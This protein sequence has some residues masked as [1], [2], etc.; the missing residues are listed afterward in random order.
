MLPNPRFSPPSSDASDRATS[1]AL[2]SSSRTTVSFPTDI[3]DISSLDG[4][5]F[6][7]IDGPYQVEDDINEGTD[8]IDESGLAEQDTL[9]ASGFQDSTFLIPLHSADEDEDYRGDVPWSS[10]TG[11]LQ[12]STSL[13]TLHYMDMKPD[14]LDSQASSQLQFPD[15]LDDSFQREL[16][17]SVLTSKGEE[18]EAAPSS[19][20]S[21]DMSLPRSEGSAYLPSPQTPVEGII[22]VNGGEGTIA[23]KSIST[24]SPVGIPFDWNK[25]MIFMNVFR[26]IVGLI[27]VVI[28]TGVLPVWPGSPVVSKL[29]LPGCNATSS[30]WIGSLLAVNSSACHDTAPTNRTFEGPSKKPESDVGSVLSS[31]ALPVIK[32]TIKR[33]ATVRY[34]DEAALIGQKCSALS[35]HLA[36]RRLGYRSATSASA[37]QRVREPEG[38]FKLLRTSLVERSKLAQQ[39]ANALLVG[40]RKDWS[41]W[42]AEMDE[43]YRSVIFPVYTSTARYA[44]MQ[45]KATKSSWDEAW[46]H[47][48][49]LMAAIP[50]SWGIWMQDLHIVLSKLHRSMQAEWVKYV[51]DFRGGYRDVKTAADYHFKQMKRAASVKQKNFGRVLQE[52]GKTVAPGRLRKKTDAALQE[53]YGQVAEKKARFVMAKAARRRLRAEEAIKKR[54]A[55]VRSLRLKHRQMMHLIE[56]QNKFSHKAARLVANGKV[57]LY[58][59][60]IQTIK[61]RHRLEDMLGN[62]VGRPSPDSIRS[63][64]GSSK[65]SKVKKAT[66][67]KAHTRSRKLTPGRW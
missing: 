52:A 4:E 7:V 51:D 5:D 14:M 45:S 23:C 2:S 55:E 62:V 64:R 29:N 9:I 41:L 26:C 13:T 25:R 63:G 50:K 61:A 27:V 37:V 17:V 56:E 1:P 12:A 57:A 16:P 53:F 30:T 39:N 11:N 42:M 59:N 49:S 54:M 22:A 60:A 38:I 32:P 44:L 67:S 3:S 40:L 10:H 66:K 35:I 47:A 20:R 21:D 43:Y 19:E 31:I 6:E 15:P 58:R 34:G 65:E 33:N 18:A 28:S 48:Y 46:A 24:P 36:E 8:D